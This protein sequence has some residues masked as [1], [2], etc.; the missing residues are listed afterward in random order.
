MN[1]KTVSLTGSSVWRIITYV[2]QVLPGLPVKITYPLLV[3]HKV[4]SINLINVNTY[5]NKPGGQ[6]PRG[7]TKLLPPLV[8]FSNTLAS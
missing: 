5:K 2:L 3:S 1:K 4:S 7:R 8:F 6:I